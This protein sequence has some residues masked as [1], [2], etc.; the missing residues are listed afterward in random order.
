MPRVFLFVLDSVGIGGAPDAA[1]FGDAG[2]NTLGHI[3]QWR[4]ACGRPLQ[5]P[6]LDRLGLGAAMRLSTGQCFP[7]LGV[8]P[9]GYWGVGVSASTGKDTTS[10][11]WEL[12]GVPVDFDWGYFPATF[13][14]FPPDLMADILDLTGLPGLLGN[15]H[16][17][18]TGIIAELGQMHIETGKP[19]C[20]TSADSVFQ[21]AAHEEYFGLDALYEMCGIVRTLVTP[22]NISRVIARPFTGNH[23]AFSRTANRRDFAVPPHRPTLLDR[24]H[25]AGNAVIGVGKVGDIFAGRG[26]TRLYKAS[27]VDGTTDVAMTAMR[28]CPDRGMVFVNIVEFD[29]EYG[30]RRDVEGYADALERFDRRVPELLNMLEADDL[31]LITA[32]HGND[33]TWHG[34]DHTREQVPVLGCSP[35]GQ[36]RAAGHMPMA[37]VADIVARHLAGSLSY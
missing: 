26:F 16:A 18:G 25:S 27:G 6:N 5:L 15:C 11:H 30:H 31:L 3:A 23:G 7:D 36:A 35:R 34:S 29:S 8:P 28:A 13:P 19:I 24:L 21:V 33:P 12:A 4:A 37:H 17:S 20:Y 14:S 10:G 1:D 9:E 22:L 2:A 32:D